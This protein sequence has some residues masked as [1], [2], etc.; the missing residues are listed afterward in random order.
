MAI[1]T[2]T[3]KSIKKA[4][5]VLSPKCEATKKNMAALAKKAGIKTPKMVATM[6][7]RIP[8]SDD[9]VMFVGL[10]GVSFYFM[11]GESVEVPE[12]IVEILKNTG[13]L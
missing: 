8:G 5:S 4:S 12:Q 9:D 1:T 7:P 6:I 10:N 3:T 2:N 11:R 13:N